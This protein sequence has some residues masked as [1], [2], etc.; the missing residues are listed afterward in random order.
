MSKVNV[1][2]LLVA[3]VFGVVLFGGTAHAQQWTN[4]GAPPT[5]SINPDCNFTVFPCYTPANATPQLRDWM[6]GT[7]DP[8]DKGVVIYTNSPYCCVDAANAV[9]VLN[10]ANAIARGSVNVSDGTVWML[11]WSNNDRMQ[12]ATSP[13]AITSISRTNNVVTVN[14]TA[15]G[16]RTR[17]GEYV[18]VFGVSDP[19]FNGTFKIASA[20]NPP[21]TTFTYNQVGPNAGPIQNSGKAGGPTDGPTNPSDRE[22]YHQITWDSRRNYLWQFGGDAYGINNPGQ[23][24]C[25]NCGATDL[26]KFDF[27]QAHPPASQVCGNLTAPCGAPQVQEGAIV[28]DPGTDVIVW[29]GGLVQGV[30]VN[31][32]WEYHVATNSWVHTCTS[33]SCVGGG[34]PPPIR[35]REGLVY[36]NAANAVIMFGG[37]GHRQ[38]GGGIQLNDTWAYSTTTHSWTQLTSQFNPIATM[39][40]VMDYNPDRQAIDY[41]TPDAPAQVWELSNINVQA[42]TASWSNLNMPPGPTLGIPANNY[43]AYDQNAHQFVVFRNASGWQVWTA[44]LG[45]NGGQAGAEVDPASLTAP[46]CANCVTLTST[47]T[48][49]L[50]I[51]SIRITGT[52]AADFAQVNNC[53]SSLPPGARCSISIAYN[54]SI[55]GNENATLVISDNAPDSPQ[56]VPL[57][58][59]GSP[60]H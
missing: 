39:F 55:G 10:T 50:F 53:G 20:P 25:S 19:S 60:Q 51:S 24:Y 9:Y 11:K 1:L 59:T 40:P 29:F 33:S 16:T 21:E 13:V 3:A 28:Y 15:P 7:Y 54:A 52:N 26:Y 43:G 32:T 41:I 49:T 22:P 45:G 17:V 18:V 31:D 34:T 58:G 36:D 48:T 37:L 42:G 47:G 5:Q 46:T 2:V 38:G 27:T 35:N 6:K 44:N 14:L 57:T 12:N 56:T 23:N 4:L 8:L 30:Q